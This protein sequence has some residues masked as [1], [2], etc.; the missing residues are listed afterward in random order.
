MIVC[1]QHGLVLSML[2]C[3]TKTLFLTRCITKYQFDNF[4]DF[5]ALKG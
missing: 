2:K 5:L 3:E 4:W 1:P